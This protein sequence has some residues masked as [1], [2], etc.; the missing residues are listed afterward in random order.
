MEPRTT[1]DYSQ[2]LKPNEF[3][4]VIFLNFFGSVT[5]CFPTFSHFL[6]GNIYNCFLMH[7]SPLLFF[8]ADNLF[9]SF[10]VAQME[11]IFF[12]IKDGLYTESYPQKK[13]GNLDN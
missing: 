4:L 13:L 11:K 5:P 8:G 7:I 12:K 10:T 3:A 1:N 6:N 2:A 9:F